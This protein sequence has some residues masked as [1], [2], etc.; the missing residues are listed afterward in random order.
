MVHGI[1]EGGE[2]ARGRVR[3][4]LAQLNRIADSPLQLDL[5]VEGENKQLIV[6]PHDLLQRS[7]Q[8]TP[9][10]SPRLHCRIAQIQDHADP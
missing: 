10:G 1:V 3:E 8:R 2:P 6:R 7:N 4:N 9:D 5:A